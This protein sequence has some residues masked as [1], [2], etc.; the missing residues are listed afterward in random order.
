MQP[1][2][3][4]LL[5]L[6]G[7]VLALGHRDYLPRLEDL[8]FSVLLTYA[9]VLGLRHEVDNGTIIL[10]L[11][12]RASILVAMTVAVALQLTAGLIPGSGKS[13]ATALAEE[14]SRGFSVGV[15]TN[16]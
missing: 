8:P 12:L 9:G 4:R 1:L 16:G 3:C 14:I 15:T 6:F 7:L 5:R 11:G 2:S 13:I 10:N